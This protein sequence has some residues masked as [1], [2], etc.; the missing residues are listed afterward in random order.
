VG[1][2]ACGVSAILPLPDPAPIN[3]PSLFY[4]GD[5]VNDRVLV[6]YAS[7]LGS[8]AQVAAAIGETLAAGGLCADVRP[9][10]ENPQPDGYRAVLIGSAV[11]HGS[12]L[13]EAIEFVKANREALKRRPVALFTVHITSLGDDENSRR[14]R[15]AFLN[16]VRPLVQ[17]VDEAFFAGRFDR[18]GAAL[19]MPAWLARFIPPLDLRNWGKI[20][21]WAASLQSRLVQN[22]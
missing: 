8:T 11:R 19:L 15:L 17:V 12:W 20:R 9:I 21:T 5:A 7:A 16:E 1:V 3:L 10:L 13:A 2:T 14:N 18:R 22:A 6:T 4:G